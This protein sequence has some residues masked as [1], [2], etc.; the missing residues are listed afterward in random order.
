M[1]AGFQSILW[2]RQKKWYDII[3][4]SAILI[5]LVVYFTINTVLYPTIT[6]ETMLIRSFGTLAII[7][8]H[9]ILS[10]GPLSRVNKKFLVLLYN[11]RHLGVA[12]FLMASVHA[13]FSIFQFHA[14]G[15]INPILSIFTSNTHYNSF[16]YFPFL[17]ICVIA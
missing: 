16:I 12:M 8:L 4:V 17:A 13:L 15:N 11:R 7:M 5:Y 14:N 10:I 9:V 6:F 2:N 1:S 3:F